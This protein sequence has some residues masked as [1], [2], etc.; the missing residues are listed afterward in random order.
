MPHR[1]TQ[2]EL[3]E[4]DTVDFAIRVIQERQESITNV[5]TPLNQKLNHAKTELED[6]KKKLIEIDYPIQKGWFK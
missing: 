5:Y 1:W 3:E 6:I 4:I 2:K